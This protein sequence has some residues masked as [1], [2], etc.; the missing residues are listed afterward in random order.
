MRSRLGITALSLAALMTLPL[1]GLGARAAGAA[2]APGPPRTVIAIQ[3]GS[4]GA[5]VSWQA[6]T[7][8]GGSPITNYVV[9][10]YKA[11]VAQPPRPFDASQ[12]FRVLYG[13]ENGTIYR[14]SVVAQNSVGPGTPSAKSGG[15]TIGAPGQPIIIWVK[16]LTRPGTVQVR[17]LRGIVNQTNGA[18]V[19][20]LNGTCTSSNGGVTGTGR[21]LAPSGAETNMNPWVIVGRLTVGKAYRCTVTAT[22]S[23]GTGIKA[24]S[25]A[26]ITV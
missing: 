14:F 25:S 21:M 8:T 11:G 15:I 16:K 17:V 10:P 9:T 5:R 13:L 23:R 19:L 26:P 6:P 7:S 12:T 24:K 4:T 20:R 18:L 3:N 22:N 2:A 1:A